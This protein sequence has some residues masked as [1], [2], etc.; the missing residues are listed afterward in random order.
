M[1]ENEITSLDSNQIAI[2]TN[3]YSK[4][5]T[6]ISEKLIGL[7]KVPSKVTLLGLNEYNDIEEYISTLGDVVFSIEEYGSTEQK[8]VTTIEEETAITIANAVLG[9]EPK[10]KG[11]NETQLDTLKDIM[12]QFSDIYNSAMSADLG[13]SPNLKFKELFLSKDKEEI[14]KLIEESNSPVIVIKCEITIGNSDKGE[15]TRIVPIIEIMNKLKIK[16]DKDELMA[17]EEETQESFSGN[18]LSNF[19]P[20]MNI[21]DMPNQE[22]ADGQPITVQ[23]VQFPSFDNHLGMS[24]EGNR[25]FDLLLDIKLKLT[26]ELGR[27]ELPIKKILELTRG[28]IIELDKIAGEPVE[29]YANGKMIA[30]GEVVVIEDNFGLRIISIVSPDDRIKNL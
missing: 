21:A 5:T 12:P 27:T 4:I 24:I 26:V 25:N 10:G 20:Q 14:N 6:S 15:I 11:I 2:L 8:A 9:K 13:S 19:P 22:N 16:E 7:V 23:P 18:T 17:Q 30:K 1:A 28:S 3:T 29:L